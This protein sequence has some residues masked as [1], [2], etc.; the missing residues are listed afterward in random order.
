MK[1]TAALVNGANDL[2]KVVLRS[3]DGAQAEI[4]RHGAHLTSWIPA[5]GEEV[6][7][8]SRASQFGP[9]MAIRGGAP[10][11]FPQFAGRGPL[12]K[13]G[14]ARLVD[15]ELV[16]TFREPPGVSAAFRLIDSDVSRKIWPHAFRALLTVAIGGQQLDLSLKVTNPGPADLT[17]TAA[18]HTYLRTAE[19]SQTVVEGL[20]GLAYLDSTAGDREMR[21][22][23]PDLSFNG[24]VDRIYLNA[25]A[26]LAV[27]APGRRLAVESAGFPD[28]VVWNPWSEK[29]A[30]LDDLEPGGYRRMVC[31][32]AAVIG[33]P[34]TLHPG[35]SW[36]GTQHLSA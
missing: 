11:I 16:E 20:G 18:L 36:Q 34:I 35:E 9:G 17:F 1:P 30:A 22:Q 12:P 27:R 15:W 3:E 21:Q 31:L 7:F 14:F 13:H 10:V 6:L 5:R 24:E 23:E 28:V 25:P 33:T 8:L 2:P 26:R 32:E 29:G 4:Y 19:I